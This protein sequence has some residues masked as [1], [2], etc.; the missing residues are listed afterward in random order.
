MSRPGITVLGSAE[1]EFTRTDPSTS[2]SFN[3][4]SFWGALLFER[5]AVPKEFCL[6]WAFPAFRARDC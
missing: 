5:T 1:H 2:D 6:F 4:A 3:T